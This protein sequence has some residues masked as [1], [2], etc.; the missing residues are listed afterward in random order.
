MACL[1]AL[2]K[3]KKVRLCPELNSDSSNK[4]MLSPHV[5][6]Y[7]NSWLHLKR[8]SN[9]TLLTQ[10]PLRRV[11]RAIHFSPHPKWQATT[12][13]PSQNL[14][15]TMPYLA[16]V[17]RFLWTRVVVFVSTGCSTFFLPFRRNV[18]PRSSGRLNLVVVD[19]EVNGRRKLVVISYCRSLFMIGHNP[20]S[21]SI[22]NNWGHFPSRSTQHRPKPNSLWGWRQHFSQKRPNTLILHDIRTLGTDF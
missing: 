12:T 7:G 10:N 5:A 20:F 19:A 13:T 8:N 18:N 14:Y 21:L 17:T 6:K 11:S 9:I 4:N 2:G 15:F 22:D 1:D 16:N 3:R